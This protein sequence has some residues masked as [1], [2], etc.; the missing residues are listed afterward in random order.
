MSSMR[1]RMFESVHG[2]SS[3]TPRRAGY[4]FSSPLY[5][6]SYH[7]SAT[8]TPRSNNVTAHFH[9]FEYPTSTDRHNSGTHRYRSVTPPPYFESISEPAF[10]HDV[11]QSGSIRNIELPPPTRTNDNIRNYDS[12]RTSTYSVRPTSTIN[13]RV[14]PDVIRTSTH[15]VR[16]ADTALYRSN[17][18][19]RNP[20][21][22][23]RMT[24]SRYGEDSLSPETGHTIPS[25][26]RSF[27]PTGRNNW[28]VSR[29]TSNR[30]V[31]ITNIV[32]NNR[33]IRRDRY[34]SPGTT[35]SDIRYSSAG[36]N[37]VTPIHMLNGTG[38]VTWTPE[39]RVHFPEASFDYELP[40]PVTYFTYSDDE[41]DGRN[42][43]ENRNCKYHFFVH[44]K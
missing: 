18:L 37:A 12:F 1:N 21:A 23:G 16:P 40:Q 32:N 5:R 22:Y 2:P 13:N 35:V 19:P 41:E 36:P 14:I 27:S 20:R 10:S 4:N 31:P 24:G 15:S 29:H 43:R 39:N 11:R 34:I 30:S 44:L 26:N 7:G 25:R 38:P 8:P 28:T 42:Y 9:S 6:R 17:S 33:D 3:R